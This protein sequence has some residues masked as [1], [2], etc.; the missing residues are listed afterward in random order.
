MSTAPHHGFLRIPAEQRSS[1]RAAASRRRAAAQ[2]GAS[3]NREETDMPQRSNPWSEA[4]RALWARIDVHPVGGEEGAPALYARLQ[5]EQGWSAAQAAAALREY[6]RYVFLCCVEPGEMT[7]SRP[8]DAVWHTHLLFTRDYWQGFCH[9]ALGRE[10]HHSPALDRTDAPRHRTQYQCTLQAYARWFGTPPQAWWPAD[11]A[12]GTRAAPPRPRL[13]RA[14]RAAVASAVLVPVAACATQGSN[15]LDWQGAD[16]LGLYLTLMPVVVIATLLWRAWL[17]RQATPPNRSVGA[18]DTS[19]IAYLA[20]G[21]GRALD[22]AV[23]EL[24]RRGVLR[25]DSAQAEL[26]HTGTSARLD[27]PLDAVARAFREEGSSAVHHAAALEALTPVRLKL[28]QRGLWLSPAQARRIGRLAALPPA[29]LAAFGFAKVAIGVARDKPVGF[30]VVLGV[31]MAVFALV[32]LLSRPGRSRHGEAELERVRS[33]HPSAK[34]LAG[35][36]GNL[37]L[38]VA[39][40]GTAILAGTGLAAYHEARA[41]SSSDGSSGS[42]GSDSSSSDS[43]SG[44]DSGGSSGCGGCGGGGGGD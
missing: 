38:A 5:R 7:P 4:Q 2:N 39:L 10:L 31:V 6:R 28:E 1:Y 43:G 23:A 34:A 24:H 33:Q 17:R 42:S 35:S 21:P 20:G 36:R 30:L 37:A 32:M 12:A 19:E 3:R 26:R 41:A 25:W 40:G 29:A 14:A 13:R 15:P 11:T 8:V 44:S 9:D 27:P 18:L 22:A 16:F